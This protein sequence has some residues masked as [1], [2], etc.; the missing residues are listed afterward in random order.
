M[1]TS[2]RFVL[3]DVKARISE[4]IRWF[5]RITDLLIISMREDNLMIIFIKLSTE[6]TSDKLLHNLICLYMLVSI[7]SVELLFIKQFSKIPYSY[8]LKKKQRHFSLCFWVFLLSGIFLLLRDL[9][10]YVF[11]ICFSQAIS[12]LRY[13]MMD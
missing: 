1:T 13:V 7:K 10:L 3:F 8:S 6:R 11:R 4:I 12:S 9:L 5:R 2:F